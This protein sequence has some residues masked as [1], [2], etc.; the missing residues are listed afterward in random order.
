MCMK[1]HA[2][3][4]D[5]S[6]AVALEP[7]RSGHANSKFTVLLLK[8]LLA[9]QVNDNIC[10][11]RAIAFDHAICYME[12]NLDALFTSHHVLHR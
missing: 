4:F 3:S 6:Y 9:E 8:N 11:L 12:S 10:L 1:K 7:C 2:K 5:C